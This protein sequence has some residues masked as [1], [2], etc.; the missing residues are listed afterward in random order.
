M[1][2]LSF[3]LAAVTVLPADRLA[4][5]D[6]LFNR[7]DYAA[8]QAEYAALTNEASVARDELLFRQGECERLLGQTTAA[9]ETYG[10]LLKAFPLSPLADRARLKRALT[11]A[12]EEQQAELKVLDSD[13]VAK[14]V[15][16][17]ALYYLGLARQ[18]AFLLERAVTL[19]PKGSYA[20]HAT[21]HRAALLAKSASADERRKAILLYLDLAFG[22]D[23]T[24]AESA[25]YL[26]GVQSYDEKRYGEA[27]SLFR[28]YL[29]TYP[30]GASA[31]DV[32]VM[33]AWCDY[34]SGK[35]A[36]AV[37]LCGAGE[38]DDFAYLKAACAYESGDGETAVR[39]LKAYLE[40]YPH[41]KYRAQAELPLARLGFDAAEKAGS[42]PQ[43]LE[44]AKRAYALSNLSGDALRLAWAYERAGRTAEA[45][46]AYDEVTQKFPK[47]ADAAEALFRKAMIAATAGRW[48]ACELSLSEVLASGQNTKHRAESLYWRGV[49][50]LQLGHEAEGIPFLER[51]LKEGL[52]LDEAR[53]ARLML[54]DYAFRSG[55]EEDA[56]VAYAQ[57]V[58]EGACERMSAAKILSVGKLVSPEEAKTCA[59]ALLTSDSAEWRQAGYLLL[60]AVEERQAAFTAAKEAYRR[61]MNETVV[62]EDLPRAVLA[63]GR[64]ELRAEEREQGERTLKRAVELTAQDP[65][66]RAEAYLELSKNAEAQGRLQDARAYA[67]VVVSLF[68]ETPSCGEAQKILSAHP[69]AAK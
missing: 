58:R 6:R 38:T 23:K 27:G 40:D 18:D 44:N 8:A 11:A 16:A 37:A 25:L 28:R 43:I 5:A 54:A 61:A 67:T 24:F 10:R 47:T 48:S 20:L 57:L 65:T 51:A 21:F 15:R 31:A 42:L 50:A 52:S 39:L 1:I 2:G 30:Q 68:S 55:K 36:D 64:L 41:G 60:G 22:K 34:L 13:R 63:L 26:A 62:T 59:R 69:E 7:G 49:A 53:E 66:A 4:L 56:K 35:F 3:L 14:E 19:D 32:R 9:R 29:K 45:E 46:A 12:D 33:T 17:A